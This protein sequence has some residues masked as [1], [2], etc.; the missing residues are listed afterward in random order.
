ME[1]RDLLVK[2]K[3]LA[4]GWLGEPITF[5]YT[6]RNFDEALNA[7]IQSA[8]KLKDDDPRKLRIN[9]RILA[10]LVTNWDITDEGVP[11]SIVPEVIEKLP[12]PLIGRIVT[13]MMAD[14]TCDDMDPKSWSGGSPNGSS[15]AAAS[16]AVRNGTQRSEQLVTSE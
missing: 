6:P 10:R 1:L 7:E 14:M 8:G 15:A 13:A 16:G 9:A 3:E 5:S 12:M 11:V 2:S 4:I